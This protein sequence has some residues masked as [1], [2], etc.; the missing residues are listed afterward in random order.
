MY[1]RVP[2]SSPTCILFGTG[3][4]ESILH[5]LFFCDFNRDAATPV[6]LDQDLR[7]QHHP[8]EEGQIADQL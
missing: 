3:Q 6:G 2:N 8:G 4:P 7:Q 1:T 5:A